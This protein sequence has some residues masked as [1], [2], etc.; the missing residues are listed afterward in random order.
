MIP[1][2]SGR[3]WEMNSFGGAYAA[4][5]VEN[6]RRL[7]ALLQNNG[8][9]VLGR[10]RGYTDAQLVIPRIGLVETERGDSLQRRLERAGILS[11]RYLRLGVQQLTR[12]GMGVREMV[13]IG[14]LVARAMHA[15]EDDERDLGRVQERAVELASAFSTVGYTFGGTADAFEYADVWPR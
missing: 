8:V 12:L 15:A 4:A 7:G 6:A 1:R 3:R 5:V 2:N 11:D 10:E 13:E 14:A 9:E